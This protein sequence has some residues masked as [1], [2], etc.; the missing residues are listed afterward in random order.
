M[1]FFLELLPVIVIIFTA[2]I[3]KRIHGTWLA[4]SSFFSLFWGIIYNKYNKK[5]TH[6]FG[7]ILMI[8]GIILFI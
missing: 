2:L 7:T 4:P 8:L 6:F 1:Q 5:I 3:L